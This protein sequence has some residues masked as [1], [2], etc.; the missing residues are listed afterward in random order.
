V[1]LTALEVILLTGN[2]CLDVAKLGNLTGKYTGQTDTFVELKT[3]LSIRGQHDET[4][5][6][7]YDWT[8]RP[9]ILSTLNFRDVSNQEIAQVLYTVVST[10]RAGENICNMFP[11]ET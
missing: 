6:E 5:F 11:P 8:T 1:K 7:R 3:S 2:Y 4:K 9:S 10:W